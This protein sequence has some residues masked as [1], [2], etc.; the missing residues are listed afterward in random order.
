MISYPTE[1]QIRNPAQ[2]SKSDV[3]VDLG[4]GN[5]SL[6]DIIFKINWRKSLTGNAWFVEPGDDCSGQVFAY[7]TVGSIEFFRFFMVVKL[8]PEEI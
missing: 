4:N 5:V 3:K 2:S 7:V 8:L 1:R 6:N